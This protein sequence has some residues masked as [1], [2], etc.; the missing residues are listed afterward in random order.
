MELCQ[1]VSIFTTV[2]KHMIKTKSLRVRLSARISKQAEV[3]SVIPGLN[4]I[5]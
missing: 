4:T 3:N 5:L 1:P 2:S